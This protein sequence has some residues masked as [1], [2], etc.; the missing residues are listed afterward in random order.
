MKHVRLF[1]NITSSKMRVDFWWIPGPDT[2]R[3]PCE[4]AGNKRLKPAFSHGSRLMSG[5]GIHQKGDKG[6]KL[7]TH[8][9]N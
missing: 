7:M 5:P 8:K 9:L 3:L 2:R 4:K 1:N 6:K